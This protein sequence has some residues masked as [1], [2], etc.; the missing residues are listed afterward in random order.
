MS[1]Q[2]L[3]FGITD[4]SMK[5][6]ALELSERMH[7]MDVPHQRLIPALMNMAMALSHRDQASRQL[8]LMT[9][10]FQIKLLAEGKSHG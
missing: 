7:G 4:A 3:P 1:K 6:D 8:F 5:A 9:L 10:E 2:P